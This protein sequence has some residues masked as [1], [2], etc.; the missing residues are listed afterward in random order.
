MK[1]IFVD[2]DNGTATPGTPV[3]TSSTWPANSDRF[4]TL[5]NAVGNTTVQAETDDITIYCQGVAADTARALFSP[6]LLAASITVQ[7]NVAGPK[8]DTTKYRIEY[9]GAALEGL[10]VTYNIGPVTLKNLQV[11]NDGT[12]TSGPYAI[13]FNTTGTFT[14]TVDSCIARIGCASGTATGYG[15][16]MGV[17]STA[18]AIVNNTIGIKLSSAGGNRHGISFPT[19]GGTRRAYNCLAYNAD[20]GI[21]YAATAAVNCVSFQNTDDFLS[22]TVSYSA[23]DDVESG[24]GNINGL[25]WADQFVD[26][27]NF[28]FNLKAGSSLIG[29]GIGPASDANVPTTDIA[30]NTR[31]GTTT[32]IGPSLYTAS[33]LSV[34]WLRLL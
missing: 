7:G 8:W 24:T 15:V 14:Y 12:N 29:A 25:T 3:H 6:S 32:D 5:G 22:S 23:S 13:R 1:Y 26:Y 18:T 4:N 10:Y 2:T 9:A 17:A 31:S 11:Q 34:G 16:R 27:A 19:S 28:D 20:Q 33:I 21:S 30:G